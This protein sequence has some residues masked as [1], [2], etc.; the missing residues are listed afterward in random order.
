MTTL[1]ADENFSDKVVAELRRLGY[2][3]LTARNAGRAGQGIPDSDVLAFAISQ[4]RAVLTFNRR[5]FTRLHMLNPAHA[6]IITCTQDHDA[7][8]LAGRIHQALLANPNLTGQLLRIIRPSRP[9][10]ASPLTTP[11]PSP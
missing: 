3:V 8:A 5:H 7:V 2:D 6:G 4:G 10:P 9:G 11:P 1:H